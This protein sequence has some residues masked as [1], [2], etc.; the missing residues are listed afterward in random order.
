MTE[1]PSLRTALRAGGTLLSAL[2]SGNG[3][4]RRERRSVLKPALFAMLAGGSAAVTYAAVADGGQVAA[5]DRAAIEA[6]VRDYI[7]T[8]PEIIPQAIERLKAKQVA[9]KVDANRTALETP[10]RGAWEG[11]EQP[12]VTLVAFMDYACGYCRAAL[13]DLARLVKDNPDLRIVYRELPI[14]AEGSVGAAKVSLLAAESGKF[15]AFHRAMYEAESVDADAV[16]KAAGS[17]G[18][19]AGK[20]RAAIKSDASEPTILENIRLAQ[21]LNAEG[22]PLFVVGD[23]VYYGSVGY[24][25]LKAAVEKARSKG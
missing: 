24:E 25:T 22:T 1:R 8:H 5:G 13:P 12:R 3:G 21:A 20:A 11:A 23:Q 17:A 6:V 9:Q 2:A 18:L 10:Y 16:L 4:Q 14:I 19:D 15:M 7:L